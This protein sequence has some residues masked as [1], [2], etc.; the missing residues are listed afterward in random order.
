MGFLDDLKRRILILDG[1]T[2]TMVQSMG[3]DEAAFRGKRFESHPVDLKGNN[4]V[5]NITAPE[6]VSSI[7]NAYIE[8]GADIIKT[9]TFSSNVVSQ[10]DFMLTDHVAE[11]NMA[12]AQLARQA[13]DSCHDRKVYVA[14][15][16]GPTGK[17]LSMSCDVNDPAA[18]AI[19]FDSM[20]QTYDTQVRALI[21]GGVDLLLLETCYDT[22]NTKAALYAIQRVNE[23]RGCVMPVMVSITIN[24]RNGHILTGQ[25]ARAFYTSIKHYPIVSFGFNCSFGIAD[26]AAP[27]ADIAA[28]LP[29]N[30]SIHPNAGLPNE[31]GQY[32]DSPEFMASNLAKIAGE[33]LINIAGG[34]CGTTPS[35]IKA[36]AQALNGMKPRV[37]PECTHRLE[38][39]GLEN[40][41]ID[42]DINNFTN[43]GERNNVA[44]SR[45]FARLIAEHNYEEAL[46]IAASQIENGSSVIDINMDDAMLDS[47][48]EMRTFLRHIASDPAVARAA[49]VIDSSSWDTIVEALKNAQGKCIVNSISL[50][51]G[52]Q[53][54][55]DKARELQ[56]LGAAVIIMAFDEQGQATTYDRKVEICG[57][58]YRLL[59]DNGFPGEDIIFDPNILSIGT[60]IDEHALYAADYIKAVKW[61]KENLPGAKTSGGLSNL[62]FAF[63]G[64]NLVRKAMH[65]VFL[66]H[67]INAGLDMAIMNPSMVLPYQDI[68]PELLQAVEDLIFNRD[69]NATQHLIEV[70]AEI[71][72]ASES[73]TSETSVKQEELSNDEKIARALVGGR[74][75]G[76]D[77]MMEAALAQSGGN[78][79]AVIEGPLMKGMERV[80][81][82]FAQG[83]LFLPQVVKSA[84]VMRDAV[85]LLQP[86]LEQYNR[87]AA[88][89]YR[90]TVV[91]ATVKGDVHD[92]GKNIV[93]I[94]LACNNFDVI[95][96]G[97]MVDNRQI[98]ETTRRVKPLMVAVSGLIT[99]SLTE[100]ENLCQLFEQEGLRVPIEVGGATTS[101]VHTAVKLAP[102]YGG[103][104][105]YSRDASHCALIAKRLAADIDAALE[106]NRVEQDVI[107]N[108]YNKTDDTTP[109]GEAC[110]KAPQLPTCDTFSVDTL[111]GMSLNP[112]IENVESLIDWRMLLAF[113]GFKGETLQDITSNEEAA[114]TLADARD[115]LEKA[116]RKELISLGT[117][118]R[119][120]P[121]SR[122]GNDIIT[123]DGTVLPMYRSQC[124]PFMS[125]ADYFPAK[126]TMPLGLFVVTARVQDTGADPKSYEHL[127]LHA[128]AARLTEAAAQWIQAKAYGEHKSIRPAFG[129]ASCPDHRLKV[130]VFKALDAEKRLGVKLTDGYSIDPSTSICGMLIAHPEAH[131]FPVMGIDNEQE[132][133][134]E[135]R[136]KSV[137]ND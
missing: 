111:N 87:Q 123:S 29:V 69:A 108:A 27:L 126:G 53:A 42:R 50:K 74:N 80:G 7:H 89:A 77:A 12:G 136:I 113:W 30:I 66:Y 58:A 65:S 120:Y 109:Y 56:R 118:T 117:E 110:G 94:I 103:G 41:V 129:Y 26:M 15:S 115:M 78:P 131:Y 40:T 36:I 125:L 84:R 1:A 67:A 73:N 98:L 32:C 52:E 17:S 112:T 35:H 70:A 8:A 55:I 9:N 134:Y 20:V 132:N 44:G 76:L 24:D 71:N 43:I 130:V 38:V 61:I 10:A 34:C 6:V 121:A 85:D 2:G 127:M 57:R 64:N 81:D 51:D 16:M 13:A 4:D 97:V 119:F 96:L 59:V 14:G 91:L 49:L 60:G 62:S 46:L 88:S 100:M 107:V 54:F 48:A 133:D 63:R 122:Q 75:D 19:D 23:E 82:L 114:R 99:P 3:M 5:L 11:L 68:Q 101:A 21:D 33:G 93:S 92:I 79:V 105:F 18:R 95:D 90:H 104:V 137:L 72:A 45:K 135:T 25:T 28:A 116:K 83:K 106:Q 86:V 124:T 39:S 37:A 31:M 22:L 47:K 128:L 102:L